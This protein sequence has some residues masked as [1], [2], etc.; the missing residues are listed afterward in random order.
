MARSTAGAPRRDRKPQPHAQAGA[1]AWES[2]ATHVF[3]RERKR[4][5][6]EP[7]GVVATIEWER[8]REGVGCGLC[9]CAMRSD[10]AC[11]AGWEIGLRLKTLTTGI[12]R[13]VLR[14]RFVGLVRA[15]MFG[16][17]FLKTTAFVNR[18]LKTDR[19]P[20]QIKLL[21]QLI[22]WILG[23][24]VFFARLHYYLDTIF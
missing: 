13:G 9:G 18:F 14:T 4:E 17:G 23:A 24:V 21:P 7:C 15:R 16:R 6:W 10:A 19:P 20:R 22:A 8:K 1:R 2:S 12:Y 3:D 5:E 11:V